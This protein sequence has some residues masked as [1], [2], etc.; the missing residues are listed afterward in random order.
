MDCLIHYFHLKYFAGECKRRWGEEKEKEEERQEG[1]GR[2][3]LF[4]ILVVSPRFI[5]SIR[6]SLFAHF[7]SINFQ[8][9]IPNADAWWLGVD[10]V[11]TKEG[12]Y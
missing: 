1:G 6:V 4:S 9:N 5:Q 10:P 8:L 7:F 2:L 11:D 3:E 12:K